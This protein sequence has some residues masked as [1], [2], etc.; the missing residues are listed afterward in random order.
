MSR[1]LGLG[2]GKVF[3]GRLDGRLIALDQ[4]N[5]EIV[6]DISAGDPRTGEGIT[7]APLYYEDMVIV[8]FT[9]GEFGVRGRISA[10]M[11]SFGSAYGLEEL[12]DVATHIVEQVLDRG[13]NSG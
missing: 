12:Q 11:A 1:G 2:D 5:G 13:L 6:W 8:G 4:Q 9:G 7:A 10:Y 3:L